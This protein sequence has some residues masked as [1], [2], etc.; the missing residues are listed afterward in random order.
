MS[1]DP[2]RK[3]P[4]SFEQQ[5]LER[6]DTL[7][8]RLERLESR[9]FDAKPI[10]ARA[11]QEILETQSQVK[12]LRAK[13]ETIEE[14]LGSLEQRMTSV[15]TEVAGLKKEFSDMKFDVRNLINRYLDPVFE[16]LTLAREEMKL[17]S[18][19]LTQ[20]ESKLI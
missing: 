20:L 3:F 15:E 7:D 17:H 9:A 16:L 1:E 8:A 13:V 4:R 5:V 18:A 2:T 11:L 14:R 6:F 12:E 19:R 10:W